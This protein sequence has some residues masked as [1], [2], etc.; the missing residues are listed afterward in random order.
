[1]RYLKELK[2]RKYVKGYSFLLFARRFG[3]K[4]GKKLMDTATRTRIDAAKTASKWVFQ[5]TA[6]ATGDLIGN[7]IADKITSLG[8]TESKEKED[9]RQE[10]YIPPEKRQQIIDELRLF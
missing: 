2:Y 10:I 6:E 1:M 4:Y 7:K 8:K 5:K 9:K 3:D